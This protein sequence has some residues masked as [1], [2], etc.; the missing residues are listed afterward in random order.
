M[1]LASAALVLV[2]LGLAACGGGGG[3]DDDSEGQGISADEREAIIAEAVRCFEE[4]GRTPDVAEMG[5]V[6]EV[7]DGKGGDRIE[8]RFVDKRKQGEY[9]RPLQDENVDFAWNRRAS[10]G[11][12]YFADTQ[13]CAGFKGYKLERRKRKR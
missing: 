11:V 10:R 3:G 8:I 13:E 7:T 6:V 12:F 9:A 2:A 1:K 4:N 5:D